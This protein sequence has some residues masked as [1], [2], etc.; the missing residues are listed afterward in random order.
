[1]SRPYDLP[2][3]RPPR[4][5]RA[6]GT[7]STIRSTLRASRGSVISAATLAVASAGAALASPMLVRQLVI[8]LGAG[9]SPLAAA[10]ALA[11][12]VLA[13]A[14]TSGMSS[15]LLGRVGE[16]GIAVVRGSIVSR[17]L[18][19]PL[20][21]VRRMGGGEL[22]ARAV[23]DTAHLRS[24][25]DVGVTAVPVSVLIVVVSLVLMGLLDWLLLVVVVATFAFAAMTM[26]G[27]LRAV[28]RGNAA[29]QSALGR[30]TEAFVAAL[31][32]LVAIKVLR[33]ERLTASPITV[34]AQEA[35]EAAVGG[36]RAQAFIAPL[37]GLSQQ[38][39]IIAVLATSGAR[40]AAG[41]LNP[42]DFVAFL[43]YLFQLVSP[44]MTIASGMARV[45]AGASAA[46]RIDEVLGR[47]PEEP[48][49][50]V[51]PDHRPASV[52]LE[53]RSVFAGYGSDDALRGVT[54]LIPARG[55]TA[56]VGA[57]GAGKS[58]I[59]GVFERFLVPRAGSVLL[60]GQDLRRWP[61]RTVR[62]RIAYVDQACTLLA[63][64]IRQ[65]LAVGCPVRPD[66]ETLMGV[67]REVDLVDAVASLPGGLDA[68]L[69]R[70]NDLSGGQ[71]Q[72]LALARALLSPADVVL[73]DEPTSHLDG[74]N[75]HRLLEVLRRLVL[76][77]A[78]VV[79]THSPSIVARAHHIIVLRDGVTLVAGS[80][81]ELI[82]TS[83]DYC[84]LIR[85]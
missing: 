83:P 6:G 54:L 19:L 69:G 45:Q 48:G 14:F 73:L 60:H 1:V 26:R 67:L 72:R 30:L 16:R 47:R 56:I 64:T 44:L 41:E 22:A 25:I 63:D 12:L 28:R 8:D 24:L 68:R 38:V 29:Q 52:V 5:G 10:G 71:R 49:P 21:D 31:G 81:D 39:A 2:R 18:H 57:S 20:L 3:H 15:F 85:A 32:S 66:D 46:A 40:L 76:S 82:K 84:E 4:G 34:H 42:S 70:G 77:R 51:E 78:V 50:A 74:I 43:M 62:T 9:R 80:H 36:L 7:L 13:G 55:L 53:L 37:V 58:T 23:A 11:A 35:A 59:F 65:N 33:A 17:V 75:E 61:L 27:L 79:A